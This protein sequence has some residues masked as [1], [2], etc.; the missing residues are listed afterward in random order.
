MAIALPAVLTLVLAGYLAVSGIAK[1]ARPDRFARV[2]I[3]TYGVATRPASLAA[4]IVPIGELGT[5]LLVVLPL[6]RTLG[7][8]AA[9]GL[10]IVVV[11]VATAAW[12]NGRTGEC[13]CFG[14][15]H[16]E[17]LGPWTIIRGGLI[18]ALATFLLVSH[19][20]AT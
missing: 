12:A 8:L 20:G 18:L 16:Q 2:L 6:T 9:V 11:A 3:Q 10:L 17:R 19:A 5:S 1:L 15:L 4:K 7:L 13:G 14:V